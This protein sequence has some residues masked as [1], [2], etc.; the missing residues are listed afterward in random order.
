MDIAT[1][2]PAEIDTA[3]AEIYG[4]L[5]RTED[6]IAQTLKYVEDYE[7]GIAKEAEGNR[8]YTG[9]TQNYSDKV[10]RMR[11]Q[12][13]DLQSQR[14][15]ILGE[16][17]PYEVE[18]SRRPWSRFFLVTNNGGHIHSSMNCSTCNKRGQA[19]RFGWLP[20]LS[21]LTEPEAVAAHGAI[22]CTVCY[23]TAPVE[24]TDRRDPSVCTGSGKTYADGQPKRVGFYSGNW[25]TCQD[26]GTRQ[27]V[28]RT[29]AIRK[30]KAPAA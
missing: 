30:H 6:Q 21:G 7:Q 23:P 4:R 24:W 14:L 15:S 3:L 1:A 9:W 29:G 5:Y 20:N 8:Q 28:T 2:S 10:L 12:I 18:Y 26:C 25:G 16:T 27:T 22:L 19:T 13:A 17:A 11:D